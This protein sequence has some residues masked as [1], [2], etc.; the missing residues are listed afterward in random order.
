M[1]LNVK[2]RLKGSSISGISGRFERSAEGSE[3]IN[4]CS[5]RRM[6]RNSL[7]C[8]GEEDNR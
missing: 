3:R 5:V 6:F 2:E 4:S 1:A 8:S 7:G